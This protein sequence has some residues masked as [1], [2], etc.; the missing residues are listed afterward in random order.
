MRGQ[1]QEKAKRFNRDQILGKRLRDRVNKLDIQRDAVD[2][3]RFDIQL[4]PEAREDVVQAAN[5]IRKS[6]ST[7]GARILA[8]GAHSIKNGLAPVLTALAEGGWITHFATNGAGI[9]HDWEFAFQG[10]SGEDVRRY[11]AEGQFGIWTETGTFINLAILLGAFRGFGYV[12]SVADMIEKDGIHLPS[13]AELRSVIENAVRSDEESALDRAAAA[14]DTLAAIRHFGFRESGEFIPV[15]HPFKEASL[16]FQSKRVGVP[17]TCHPMFGHDIIYTHPMN[18]GAAIGRCAERDFLSFVDSV[19]RL[20]GG[21][22]LSVGS[23]VMSP[24]IF[25]KAL[26]MSRNTAFQKKKTIDDFSIHVVDLA[27]SRWDWSGGGEPPMDDPAY[28]LRFCKTF[29]R[30]GGRMTY[31]SADNR[32]W[33]VALLRELEKKG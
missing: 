15:P 8:F 30:M 24:M 4:T 18:H 32:S 23:A 20:D 17:F 28:Y 29:S 12:E 27:A 26:S 1:N 13:A 31:A 7:D 2:P 21:V 11:A 19:S 5:E 9:I 33:L 6:K 14:A 25:E 3:A 22:Y 16:T 10:R